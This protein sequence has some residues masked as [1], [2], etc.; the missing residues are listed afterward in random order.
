MRIRKK[1]YAEADKHITEYVPLLDTQYNR[2]NHPDHKNFWDGRNR[3]V[4]ITDSR[5]MLKAEIMQIL[6][7]KGRS[8]D[9]KMTKAQLLELYKGETLKISEI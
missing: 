8:Y 3:K 9:K 6:E 7:M 1:I 4:E 2:A 5:V